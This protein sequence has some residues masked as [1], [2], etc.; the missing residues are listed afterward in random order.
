MPKNMENSLKL[1]L[2][3]DKSVNNY[4]ISLSSEARSSLE[5][6]SINI[7]TVE[8]VKNYAENIEN[9]D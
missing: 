6:N 8:D 9:G 7:R 5:K 1:L 4:Y 3:A 2:K